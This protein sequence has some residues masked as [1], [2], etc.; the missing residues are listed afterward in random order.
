M[1]LISQI[2]YS[3][4]NSYTDYIKVY[5]KRISQIKGSQCSMYPSCSQYGMLAFQTKNPIRAFSLT[6][7]RLMRCG[8]EHKFYDITLQKQGFRLIDFLDSSPLHKDLLY[9]NNQYFYAFSDTVFQENQ[10]LEFVKYLMN[11]QYFQQALLEISRLIYAKKN[12]KQIEIYVNYLICLRALE[13]Q[14][15]GIFEYE[16]CFPLGAKKNSEILMQMGHL[17]LDLE[18]YKKAEKYYQLALINTDDFE[19]KNKLH[20]QN[21]YAQIKMQKFDVAFKTYTQIPNH[22]SYFA[23]AQ[24]NI[25]SLTRLQAMPRKSPKLAGVLSIIPG[26]GYFYSSHKQTAISAFFVNS[27]LM[28]ATYS[29]IQKENYG[30]AALT[31]VFSFSFYIGNISGATRSAKRYNKAQQKK[32]LNKINK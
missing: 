11:K 7:D 32:L 2:C 21:A 19:S 26:L 14:E 1:L 24:S 12:R 22:S 23:K 5:Q 3:Q 13:M 16:T 25:A 31:G 30:M 17:Y 15:K 29:C 20:L 27:L 10:S 4:E 6:A 8:H 9:T 18:N 28:Y